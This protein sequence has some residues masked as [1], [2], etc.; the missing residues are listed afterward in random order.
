MKKK[1]INR[2]KKGFGSIRGI[3]TCII[4]GTRSS[5]LYGA[6]L[7]KAS[8]VD[9][10][11]QYTTRTALKDGLSFSYIARTHSKMG[12]LFYIVRVL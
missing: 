10:E 8:F 1:N 6:Y 3:V 2:K 4:V 11:S 7:R 9:T 5:I 12:Y